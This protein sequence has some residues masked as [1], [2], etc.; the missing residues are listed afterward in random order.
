MR[1]LLVEDDEMLGKS[2]ADGL[3]ETGYAIDWV[4]SSADALS[5]L[6]AYD[7]VLLL[8][9]LGLPDASGLEL[10]ATARRGGRVPPTLVLTA[11]DSVDV[12]VQ[13]LDA[14]ADDYIVK[15]CSIAELTAR[16]RAAMRRSGSDADPVL[17]CGQVRLDPRTG[18]ASVGHAI[19]DRQLTKREYALFH[20]LMRHPGTILSRAQL[21]TQI[22]GW[23]EEVE[24]NAVEYLIRAV[25]KKLGKGVIQ[26]I[27][28][29]GWLATDPD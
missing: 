4:R 15:P 23:G 6:T 27:R 17:R 24:S 12:C 9:D 25:R 8:L 19:V 16:M 2:L 11:F 20:A 18:Q 28:G 10:L 26:N 1:V 22:Y 7:Y 5:A 3:R 14:G 13:G 29:L 21:E